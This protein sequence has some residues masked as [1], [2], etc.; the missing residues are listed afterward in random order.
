MT[1]YDFYKIIYDSFDHLDT[2][3]SYFEEKRK[4]SEILPH[5]YAAGL[6][7]SFELIKKI[8]NQTDFAR[9]ERITSNDKYEFH[10]YE[11]GQEIQNEEFK[12]LAL[13]GELSFPF[14]KILN[15]VKFRNEKFGL[16][17][18]FPPILTPHQVVAR[19]DSENM[20]KIESKIYAYL[21]TIDS[22]T[23]PQQINQENKPTADQIALLYYYQGKSI[24]LD[25]VAEIA[26]RHGF[27][28][29]RLYNLFTFY[30]NNTDRK[31][32]P[33]TNTKIRFRNKIK[34]F[35][36]VIEMLASEYKLKA[37]AE[38]TILTNLYNS[39]YL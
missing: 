15:L 5:E 28:G 2:P 8:V 34:L 21:L 38:L 23:P 11:F 18:S 24:T 19:F 3:Q 32:A 13:K 29:R 22:P 9:A 16:I 17:A 36:S 30:S 4:Q 35:E 25:N 1:K 6:K 39:D 33:T 14:K 26:K 7:K 31:A 10:L 37:D 20:E 12:T 27:K